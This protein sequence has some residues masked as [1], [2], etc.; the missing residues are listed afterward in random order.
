MRANVKF[1]GYAE[2]NTNDYEPLKKWIAT[3]AANTDVE[4]SDTTCG[5]GQS[6]CIYFVDEKGEECCVIICDGCYENNP[7]ERIY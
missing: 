4:W 3:N 6:D 2:T 7:S 1:L 5:C